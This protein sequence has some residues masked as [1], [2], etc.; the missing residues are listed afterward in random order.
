M[1][2]LFLDADHYKQAKKK[3]IS[4]KRLDHLFYN[5]NVDFHTIVDKPK[6][7]PKTTNRH[8]FSP[9]WNE[10][11]DRAV[12]TRHTMRER[13][14]GG[15]TAEEAALTPNMK[16]RNWNAEEVKTLNEIGVS[17]ALATS[18][19]AVGWSKEEVLNTPKMTTEERLERVR[20]GV[21]HRRVN[22]DFN[23]NREGAEV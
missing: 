13:M 6:P 7:I 19:L 11:N 15:M 23:K 16:Q 17:T 20:E 9:I 8:W 2:I 21:R 4:K 22:K 1:T 18:R 14:N 3:G 10:W 12:V 5:K